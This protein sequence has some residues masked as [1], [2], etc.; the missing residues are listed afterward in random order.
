MIVGSKG[1]LGEPLLSSVDPQFDPHFACLTRD[2]LRRLGVAAHGRSFRP[3]RGLLGL[4]L[5]TRCLFY[6]F[7]RRVRGRSTDVVAE[8]PDWAST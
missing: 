1:T 7:R 3:L 4:L 2:G 8:I 5:G 6:A